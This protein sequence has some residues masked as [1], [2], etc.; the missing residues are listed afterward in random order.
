MTF[1]GFNFEIVLPESLEYF[2]QNTKA[3]FMGVSTDHH[4]IYV[5][6]TSIDLFQNMVQKAL[7]IGGT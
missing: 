6:I 3:L 7:E 1:R 5:N 2:G 4:I